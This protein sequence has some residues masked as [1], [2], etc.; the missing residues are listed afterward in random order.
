VKNKRFDF[1]QT[2]ITDLFILQRNKLVDDRG[3]FERL[4]CSFELEQN[5][6]QKG[7][8]QINHTLTK[9]K[10]SI[11]GLHMQKKPFE[12]IKIISC[13]KGSVFDVALDLRPSS[14]TYLKWFSVIL[15]DKKFNSLII[16]EGFA[17][18]FQ[19][20]SDNCELIYFHSNF[21][22]LESEVTI[23]PL[24][25]VLNINWPLPISNLSSKD[26]QG[27]MINDFISQQ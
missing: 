7:I 24:D 10:G 25:I 23:N 16:P 11:R 20:M 18:G 1:V 5:L 19:T 4:F 9:K 21:Y 26:K 27:W 8:L 15:D 2:P 17:H 13:L 3:Y 12:E 22:H 6:N 14:S